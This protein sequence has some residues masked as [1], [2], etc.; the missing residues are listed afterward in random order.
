M[1][2]KNQSFVAYGIS[3]STIDPYEKRIE[4]L[5]KQLKKLSK[6]H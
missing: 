3:G 2:T 5:E 1:E 4:E 6:E